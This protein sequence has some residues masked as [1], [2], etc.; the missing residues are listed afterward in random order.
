[1]A[2]CE[3]LVD[4]IICA[5]ALTWSPDGKVLYFGDSVRGLVWRWDC[6]PGSGAISNRRIFVEVPAATGMPDG[7][8]V[9]ADGFVWI[10]HW[11]GWR[12]VRYDPEGRIDRVLMVPVSQPS[13]PA[14]G[15]PDLRTLYITSAAIGVAEPAREPLA[16]GLF[17]V[18]VG[19]TGLAEVPYG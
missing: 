16:G 3:R 11:G 6:D 15:G 13:C 5:N 19:V 14:F 9:D 18:E 12:V 8:A 1:M 10:A 4:G 7:A 17:A 2:R